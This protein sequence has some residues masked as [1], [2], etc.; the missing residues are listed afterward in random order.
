MSNEC[1]VSAAYPRSVCCGLA[2]RCGAARGERRGQREQRGDGF[3]WVRPPYP[4]IPVMVTL[5]V[6][7]LWSARKTMITGRT[8][9]TEPAI[10]S[11]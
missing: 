10:S 4:L 8:S 3:A 6:K 1:H 2:A 11:P 5:C 9:T 7:C